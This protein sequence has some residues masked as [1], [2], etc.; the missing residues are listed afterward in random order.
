MRCKHG[1]EQD[2]CANCNPKQPNIRLPRTREGA[3]IHGSAAVIF[4]HMKQSIIHT[5]RPISQRDREFSSLSPSTQIVHID[6]APFLWA[7][8]RILKQA[9]GVKVIQLIPT[10]LR[11][12]GPGA[13]K[14]CHDSG[15][16]VVAG[17]WRP[18]LVWADGENRSPYY[19][20]QRSFLKT[21]VGEQKGLFAELLRFNFLPA[22]L[23]LRYFCL[24][25]EPY[26]TLSQLI[27]DFGFTE[28]VTESRISETINSAFCYLDSEF[29][30]SERSV[31]R[32]KAMRSQ[33][34]RMR[35]QI[36]IA[37]HDRAKRDKVRAIT[38]RGIPT[39]LPFRFYDKYQA[40]VVALLE[41]KLELLRNHD[42]RA[43]RDAHKLVCLRYGFD[44]NKFRTFSSLAPLFGVSKQRVKQLE[45]IAFAEIGL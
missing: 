1:I 15:V 25:G 30:A 9:P 13:T 27:L 40:L 3:S 35:K 10:N 32:A 34:E 11:R 45:Q 6:G 19:K 23:A 37:E 29:E 22:L 5:K 42:S 7:V 38:G 39:G 2:W 24:E 33:V 31:Q 18:E 4:H 20:G 8:E 43:H 41:G 36:A 28:A 21:L 16:D 14:L 44:D 26:I 17:H 12:L